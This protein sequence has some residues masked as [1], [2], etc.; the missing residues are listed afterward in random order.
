MPKVTEANRK[1]W[2]LFATR[3]LRYKLRRRGGG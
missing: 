2:T 1:W 3:Q